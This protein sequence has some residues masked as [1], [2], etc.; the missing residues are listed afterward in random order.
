MKNN[1]KKIFRD[2]RVT[3]DAVGY[4]DDVSIDIYNNY[5][6]ILDIG[7]TR[8]EKRWYAQVMLNMLSGRELCELLPILKK[9]GAIYIVDNILDRVDEIYLTKERILQLVRGGIP[10]EDIADRF[11]NTYNIWDFIDAGLHP[12]WLLS[13]HPSAEDVKADLFY[14]YDGIET[15]LKATDPANRKE[16]FEGFLDDYKDGTTPRFSRNYFFSM[17][18]LLEAGLT[19]DEV[20]TIILGD[21]EPY[22]Q[23]YEMFCDVESFRKLRLPVNIRNYL[24][25]Y[26]K[27]ASIL[28]HHSAL[29]EIVWVSIAYGLNA[30]DVLDKVDINYLLKHLQRLSFKHHV[31]NYPT[32]YKHFDFEKFAKD[33]SNKTKHIDASSPLFKPAMN[34]KKDLVD[35]LAERRPKSGN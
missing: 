8:D 11:C 30:N 2:I 20:A 6:N 17:R 25:L 31:W 13:N 35:I 9:Y 14:H 19:P 10:I 3:F 1:A 15:L 22:C 29:E 33:V 5:L 23:A 27:G 4:C 28:S 18:P 24:E 34:L 12:L 26:F 16:F 7:E 21:D 32:L